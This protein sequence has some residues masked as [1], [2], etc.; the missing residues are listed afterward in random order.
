MN[1][2]PSEVFFFFFM[3]H[4]SSTGFY[5]VFV[6]LSGKRPVFQ[7]KQKWKSWDRKDRWNDNKDDNKERSWGSREYYHQAREH[8]RDQR[9]DWAKRT[10]HDRHDSSSDR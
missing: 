7:Y 6:D 8:S 10:R 9:T 4:F 5:G 2:R 3:A 1:R